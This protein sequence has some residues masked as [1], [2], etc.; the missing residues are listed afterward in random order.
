MRPPSDDRFSR[1]DDFGANRPSSWEVGDRV[2][3]PWEP[4]FLYAGTLREVRD[5]EAH[6]GFDDGD[7]GWVPLSEVRPLQVEIEQFV[8]C[9][10]EMGNL[11]YPATVEDVS[12][13]TVHVRFDDGGAEW[14][15]VAAVRLPRE[16]GP[17]ASPTRVGS[18]RAFVEKLRRG[19]RVLAPWENF[20]LYPATVVD[21]T[22]HEVHVQYDDGDAGCVG[23]IQVHPLELRPGLSVSVRGS[24]KLYRPGEIVAAEGEDVEVRLDTGAARTVKLS[25]V[26]IPCI[27]AGDNARPTRVANAPP[28]SGSGWSWWATAIVIAAVILGVKVVL[29]LLMR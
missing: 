8:L 13:E 25:D 19:S 7:S 5:G 14:T 29:R 21:V 28:G 23:L 9:R 17:G 18:E 16:P 2:L 4:Q 15:T 24:D 27:P 12:G 6:V 3:A 20:F 22:D 11:F 26:R 10:K 1:R